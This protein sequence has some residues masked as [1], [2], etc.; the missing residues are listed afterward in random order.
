MK[1]TN[2]QYDFWKWILWKVVP[3]FI[4][5]VSTLGAIFNFED[6]ANVINGVVGAFA[7]FLGTILG[8]S[9]KNYYKGK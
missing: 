4:V 5:L 9:T 6:I 7:I 1:L 3:A 2:K 8:I